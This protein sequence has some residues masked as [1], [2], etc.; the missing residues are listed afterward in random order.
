[1]A[2]G[3]DPGNL[4]GTLTSVLFQVREQFWP[5]SPRTVVAKSP[6]KLLSLPC[7]GLAFLTEF[8]W[9]RGWDRDPESRSLSI[10]FQLP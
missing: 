2:L 5:L 6:R 3:R 7:R 9:E 1:M 8:K 10:W 4:S